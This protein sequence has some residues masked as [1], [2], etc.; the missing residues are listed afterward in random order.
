MKKLRLSLLTACILSI[1]TTT[2][3]ALDANHG[4]YKGEVPCPPQLILKDGLYVGAQAGYD[5]YRVVNDTDFVNV[6]PDLTFAFDPRLNASGGVGGAFVGFGHYFTS[7]HNVYLGFE[8]FGNG[9]GA[10]TDSQVLAQSLISPAFT[11]YST[12]I[13]VKSNYG[14]SLLPGFKLN[15]AT[16]VY[17][18]LGYNWTNIDVNDYILVNTAVV[19]NS[20]YDVTSSGF[21]YGLGLETAVVPNVSVRGEFTHTDYSNFTTYVGTK[22]DP[23]DNQ[24]MLALI[25][26]LS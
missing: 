6:D 21:N 14:L 7:F 15:N 4:N 8:M 13:E 18:R 1:T 22:V 9:S 11:K 19:A 10:E 5:S 17:V 16:L 3:A 12:D 23:Q 2:Y 24:F 26:H 20:I 25:L